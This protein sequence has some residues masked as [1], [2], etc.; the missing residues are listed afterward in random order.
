[1]T[2]NKSANILII[3]AGAIGR[4]YIAPLFQS[5]GYKISFMDK[6]ENLIDKLKR[7]KYTAAFSLNNKYI[8]QDVNVNKYLYV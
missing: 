5:L 2:R 3:G 8:F 7:K 4:G 1:M 6:N